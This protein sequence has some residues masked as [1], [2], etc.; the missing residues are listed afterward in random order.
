MM[1][2]LEITIISM[3]KKYHR[4]ES[5]VMFVFG[6]VQPNAMVCELVCGVIC[7]VNPSIVA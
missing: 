1:K 5:N 3:Q 7:C 6:L 4:K 2:R